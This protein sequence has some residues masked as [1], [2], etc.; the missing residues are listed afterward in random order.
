MSTILQDEIKKLSKEQELYTGFQ[1]DQRQDL[2][3]YRAISNGIT[4]EG[5]TISIFEAKERKE[6]AIRMINHYQSDIDMRAE[7]LSLLQKMAEAQEVA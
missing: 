2:E 5:L 1:A 6:H 3:I 4:W 7:R